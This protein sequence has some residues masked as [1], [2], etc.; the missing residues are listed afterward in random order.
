[1]KPAHFLATLAGWALPL[2]A[3]AQPTAFRISLEKEHLGVPAG[4][5]RVTQVL[6]ARADHRLGLVR[7]G[8]TNNLVPAELAQ[9]L[10]DE[11]AALLRQVPA[12]PPGWPEARPVTLRI[13]ALAVG[14][15]LRPSS[16]TSEAELVADFL[17]PQPD[18]TYRVLLPVGD[19]QRRGGLDV[20]GH[21]ATN[22][23]AL[24]E[25]AMLQLALS[26]A[27]APPTETLTR[28]QALAGQGGA[29]AVRY[30][31]LAA[32]SRSGVYH[33]FAEFRNHAPAGEQ[34]P[35]TLRHPDYATKRQL[36]THEL[37]AEYVD[38][39]GGTT[40]RSPIRGAWGLNVGQQDFIF[41]R[42]VCYPIRPSA[43]GRSF[44]FL[45]PPPYNPEKAQD[46]LV[47]GLAFGLIGAAVASA[48]Y[49]KEARTIPYE[50]HLATGRV[51]PTSDFIDPLA[52]RV[53]TAVVWVFR[54]PAKAKAKATPDPADWNVLL[55]GKLAGILSPKSCVRLTW[56]SAADAPLCL[57][58]RP[59]GPAA[60]AC[61]PF[62]PTPGHP[63]Y[64]EA[65]TAPGGALLLAPLPAAEA[66]WQMRRIGLL[67]RKEHDN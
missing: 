41:Y 22:I 31:A 5:W 40:E 8:L 52:T 47:G 14:E 49:D 7:V 19:Y 63:L 23:A 27:E 55:G 21:H 37:E 30:P 25:K 18:S 4:P 9:P 33:S 11:V 24:F 16:E 2:A 38:T 45:A 60:P 12:R 50:I 51:V 39:T 44:T 61:V 20:T 35:F 10:P 54:R 6:D 64:F 56:L 48:Q 1:M 42:D 26:P 3:L 34:K 15:D 29:W 36:A 17:V 28:A 46:V 67:R 59:A 32:P 62:H 57:Q 43:D 13:L 53:D 66:Q 65:S 58:E